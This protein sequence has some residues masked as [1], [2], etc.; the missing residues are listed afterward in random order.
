MNAAG[1]IDLIRI[2]IALLSY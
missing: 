2:Y 1:L